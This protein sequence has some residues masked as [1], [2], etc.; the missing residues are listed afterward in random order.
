MTLAE[1]IKEVGSIKA[2][3]EVS[4]SS[5]ES[6]RAVK[7]ALTLTS[8]GSNVFTLELFKEKEDKLLL[9]RGL[10]NLPATDTQWKGAPSWIFTKT[11]RP[12]QIPIVESVFK[13]LTTNNG[14]IIKTSLGAGKTVIAI[15]LAT[16]IGL[17]TLIIVPTEHL[18][19]QWTEELKV[20]SNLKDS[21]IGIIRQKQCDI[22]DKT[23][24]IALIHSLARHA[25]DNYYKLSETEFG[26]VIYEEIH[27]LGAETFSRTAPMFWSKYRIGLSGTPRRK[28]GMEN[29]FFYHI[30]KVATAYMHMPIKPNV[31]IA[32]YNQ[33]DTHH[34]GCVWQGKLNLGRYFNRVGMSDTRNKKLAKVINKLYLSDRNILAMGDR[35]AQLET[36]KSILKTEYKLPEQHI[37]KFTNKVKQLDRRILLATYGSAG[38]GAN[39]PRLDTLIFLTP[40][41]DVEQAIGRILRK[42]MY[43]K[44]PVVI[45]VVD[46][47][48]SIMLGWAGSRKKYYTK[49]SNKI[50]YINL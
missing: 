19:R 47:A 9:P 15:K 41:T 21:D 36:I 14:G 34:N 18:V 30:G 29:V 24:V 50:N 42:K 12:E 10:F 22:K 16:M 26:C 7:S 2:Y 8:T 43:E 11:L 35:L 27:T 20:F 40:R 32:T 49:I 23:V 25:N 17:K 44:H 33:Q 38:L 6:K 4:F 46:S 45:D 1:H 28:D 39:I 5:I 31:I 3:A 13:Y 37:G 48:S